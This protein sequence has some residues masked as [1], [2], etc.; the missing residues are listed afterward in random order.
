VPELVSVGRNTYLHEM[1]VTIGCENIF[2]DQIGVIFP[3][4]E[5][6]LDRNPDLIFTCVQA[7]SD[8]VVEILGRE[9]FAHVAAIENRGVYR[10]DTNSAS[11]PSARI[12]LALKQMAKAAY[13]DIYAE[14]Q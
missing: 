10:V 6:I 14:L 13:P 8:P 11:R 3:S 7:D 9:G 4:G 1:M 2:A 5:A 12:L